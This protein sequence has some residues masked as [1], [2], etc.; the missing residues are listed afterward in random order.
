M[1]E[2]P[3]LIRVLI[4]RRFPTDADFAAAIGISAPH[5]SNVIRGRKPLS[6]KQIDAWADALG[7]EGQERAD[8]RFAVEVANSP[9]AIAERLVELEKIVDR[10]ERSIAGLHEKLVK[11]LVGLR[12]RPGR[13]PPKR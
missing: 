12:S 9:R 4:D 6:L 2:F 5:A 8:F 11:A 3:D 7:L 13:R 1:R 10:Q